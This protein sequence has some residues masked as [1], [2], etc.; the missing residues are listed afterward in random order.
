MQLLPVA[1][2]NR[3]VGAWIA[4]SCF[5][6]QC[7]C[8]EKLK[9]HRVGTVIDLSVV[10]VEFNRIGFICSNKNTIKELDNYPSVVTYPYSCL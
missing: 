3:Y 6:A 7:S 4:P 8:L 2:G 10:Q 9:R 1:R 5:T